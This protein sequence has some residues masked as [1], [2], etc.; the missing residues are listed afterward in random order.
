MKE[1]NYELYIKKLELRALKSYKIVQV[2]KNDIFS[3]EILNFFK[4]QNYISFESIKR[5]LKSSKEKSF[6]V[7]NVMLHKKTNKIVGFVGTL[8]SSKKIKGNEIYYCNIHTW[9]VS[10]NH[11]LFSFFLIL[12]LLKK[13]IKLT[14]FTAVYT[15]KGLLQKFGFEKKELLEKFYFNLVPFSFRKK[16][17]VL[18]NKDKEDNLLKITI[19]KIKTLEKITLFGN[20][21]KK[22]GLKV[23]K[24]LLIDLE[25]NIEKKDDIKE[26]L[27]LISKEYRIFFFSEFITNPYKSLLSPSNF[28]KITKRRDIFLKNTKNIDEFDI[29]N[30]DL[31]F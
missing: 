11:R 16:N 4:T 14:A 18:L 2:F 1:K 20:I 5:I 12:D 25:N 29:L 22:K 6:P 23:F 9:I 28:L 17:F 27:N 8:F 3:E 24:I 10:K 31:A 30:S 15:L 21:I 19:Q 26:I 7:A 13:E